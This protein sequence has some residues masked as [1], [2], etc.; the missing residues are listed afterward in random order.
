MY[1]ILV[2]C[3]RLL[4]NPSRTAPVY[5]VG[6]SHPYRFLRRPIILSTPSCFEVSGALTW[7]F[8]DVIVSDIRLS[9]TRADSILY[10]LKGYTYPEYS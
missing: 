9:R 10:N 7:A 8:L 6:A 1:K 4:C 5:S 3:L 2:N